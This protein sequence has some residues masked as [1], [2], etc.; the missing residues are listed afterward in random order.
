MCWLLGMTYFR[1]CMKITWFWILLLMPATLNA[2]VIMKGEIRD[3]STQDFLSDVNVRNIYTLKGM[4]VQADGKFSL[5]VKKGE[6]IECSKVGYQT[7]RVRIY[8]EKEP[9]YYKIV[10]S[11]TPTMLRE[12][13]VRGKPLDFVRDSIR[14]RETYDIVLRKEHRDEVDM[15]NMPLAMLSKKNRQE[16]AFQDMYQEWE[17]EKYI[18]F[19]FNPRLVSRITYLKG[20]E[21]SLFMKQYRPS[22]AFLRSA[23]EYEYLSFI[24]NAYAQ[25]VA[26]KTR[27]I[28]E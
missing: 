22:Y 12:V 27:Q 9:D 28:R 11:K 26:G 23:S 4:T 24:K 2:Q 3:E 21:L 7:V 14:Y 8:S 1:C 18:D 16:W 19:T 17:H 25:F 6:L 13:D 20:E 10:M 5:S 15:R